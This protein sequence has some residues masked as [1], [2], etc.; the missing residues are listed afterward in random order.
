MEKNRLENTD[1]EVSRL[2]FGS[3]TIMPFQ[4]NLPIDEGAEL[5]KYAYSKGVN[6]LDTAEFYDN[7]EYIRVYT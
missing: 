7:Y 2:C 1:I 4:A 6:F 5:I 3:L